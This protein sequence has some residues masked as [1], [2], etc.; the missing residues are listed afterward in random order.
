MPKFKPQYRRL[1]YIDKTLREGKYPN[2]TT[3]AAGWE[4]SAKTIQRDIAYLTD[5]LEAPIEYDSIHRG[6]HYTEDN[7]SL[8]AI[9]ISESDLFAVFIAQ[10]ALSPF[11]NTPL[12]GKL[13]SVFSKI[14]DSLPDQTSIQPSWL[15]D[16]ILVFPEPATTINPEV[17]DTV[18]KAIRDNRRLMIR[19]AAPGRNAF[20]DRKIDPYYLASC[21]GEWY[22]SSFCHHR[23]AIRTFGVSR[24]TKAEILQEPFTMPVSLTREKMYG[25]QFGIIWKDK[26]YKVR[27]CIS[28]EIAPY[29]KERKWHPLQKIKELRDGRLILEFTTNHL[30]EVKDWVLSKG[31]GARVLAPPVLVER[32]RSS[33]SNAL[34][35]YGKRAEDRPGNE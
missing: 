3:L 16:R 33:L 19:H 34:R 8:P 27:I 32:V 2:C 20:T 21:K 7:Y 30:N 22:V 9:N 10:S 24:I 17:W 26:S 15:D 18:A 12:H 28:A 4:V 1:I 13:E 6:Y 35:S 23:N 25:D 11:K 14:R 31:E 29:I 5:E